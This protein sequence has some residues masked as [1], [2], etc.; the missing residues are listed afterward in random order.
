MKRRSLIFLGPQQ[1]AVCEENFSGPGSGQVLVRTRMSAISSGTEML[2]YGGHVPQNMALDAN[3]ASLQGSFSFPF[4]YGY[5]CVGIVE[6]IGAGVDAGWLG[7]SVFSFHPHESAF[8]AT[9]EEL[10]PIAE[11]VPL[12]NAI[13]LA[14]METAVNFLLDG[15]PLMGE[16]VGVFG[17]GIVGL[18][19]TALLARFP[20]AALV[21]F[22]RYPA[23][24]AAA[25][26]L[27]AAA[28]FDPAAENA[29]EQ[30]TEL[31]KARS[32]AEGADLVYEI[33][34]SPRAL[35]QAIALA[36]FDARV[37]IGSWYGDKPVELDLGGRFHRSRIRLLS[38]QVSTVT[39]E[40]GG[41]WS[42]ARRLQA[43]WD[44]LRAVNPARWITHRFPL[45][46][47]PAAYQLLAER[48]QDAIQVVLE[49]S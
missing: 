4:K 14:N 23:R 46:E 11:D 28:S 36:G 39:P 44:A 48:P 26:E 43:A 20:L 42:K 22:D 10:I 13:F 15:R 47:A 16:S 31:M 2:A 17:L 38:S 25:L 40:L 9:T 37:V 32:G 21:T 29:I 8:T 27:G 34:G 45:S 1:T 12:D 49:Y 35:D 33:S 3:I 18:L 6:E 41:R 5:A 7:R 19:T 24:R 30:A